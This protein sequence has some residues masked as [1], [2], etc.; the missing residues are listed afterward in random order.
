M[1]NKI[2][3][4]ILVI[5]TSGNQCLLI[6]H[7]LDLLWNRYLN[8]RGLQLKLGSFFVQLAKRFWEG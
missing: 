3:A 2:K 8:W 7:I 6:P 1:K 4:L 5:G